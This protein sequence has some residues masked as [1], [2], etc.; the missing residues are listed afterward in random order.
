MTVY[1][2]AIT[3]SIMWIAFHP[4]TTSLDINVETGL[5]DCN[6]MR[7]GNLIFLYLSSN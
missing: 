5:L 7:F 6:V 3:V 4:C 2:A 1:L